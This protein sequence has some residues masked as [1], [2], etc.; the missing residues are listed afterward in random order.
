MKRGIVVLAKL[1]HPERKAENIDIF[2]FERS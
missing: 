1:V 2:D